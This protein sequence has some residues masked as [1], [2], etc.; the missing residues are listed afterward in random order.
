MKCSKLFSD[1][2]IKSQLEEW[3]A[4][5]L[6]TGPSCFSRAE[7]AAKAAYLQAGRAEPSFIKVGSPQAAAKAAVDLIEQG[8]SQVRNQVRNQ[9]YSQVHAQVH[10]Q[11]YNQVYDQVSSQVW[12]QVYSQVYNQVSNC[13][14]RFAQLARLTMFRDIEEVKQLDCF[15]SLAENTGMYLLLNK[16]VIFSERPDRIVFRGTGVEKKA[17]LIEYPD[18]YTVTSLSPLEQ[19]A[20]V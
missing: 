7:A 4:I 10:N 1:Q 20:L 15:V 19:L 5:G 9:V 13:Y 3:V 18:G 12:R 17:V 11:V 14:Y 6:A 2:E 8:S 16:T